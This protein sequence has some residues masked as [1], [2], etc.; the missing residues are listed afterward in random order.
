MK[1]FRGV[2]VGLRFAI[3]SWF[4]GVAAVALVQDKYEMSIASSLIV[5]SLLLLDL[6][7]PFSRGDGG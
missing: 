7:K 6:V 2:I 4:V 3:L 1:F 5:I